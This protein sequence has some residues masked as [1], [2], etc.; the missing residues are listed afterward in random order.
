M[1]AVTLRRRLLENE[2]GDAAE[3]VLKK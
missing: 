2:S 1:K 3:E